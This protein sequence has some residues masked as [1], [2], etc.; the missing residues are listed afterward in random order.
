GGRVEGAGGG[1]WIGAIALAG[2]VSGLD[3]ARAGRLL[4]LGAALI[5]TALAAA[6]GDALGGR[7]GAAVAAIVWAALPTPSLY[8]A[9][10]LETAAFAAALWGVA[11]AV[12]RDRR[13]P[14]AAAGALVAT[15]RPEGM[16]LALA[17]APFFRRLG[18]AGRAALAGAVLGGGLI[19]AARFACYG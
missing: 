11:A 16:L 13:S 6:A 18:R 19:A 8:A 15:L 5:A 14:A 10:G 2:E 9:T 1:V 7:R 17:A 4:S 12:A 3:A